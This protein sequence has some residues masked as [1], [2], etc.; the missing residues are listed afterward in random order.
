MEA[1]SLRRGR[2]VAAA[3]LAVLVLLLVLVAQA[4]ADGED[5][6]TFGTEGTAFVG[7]GTDV[8]LNDPDNGG[9][10]LPRSDVAPDGAI[11]TGS[12]LR[13]GSP[14]PPR[15]TSAEFIRVTR[16]DT[17]GTLAG[18]DGDGSVDVDYGELDRFLD[19]EVLP[20][21]NTMLVTQ[22][23]GDIDDRGTG[24][25]VLIRTLGPDGG[26]IGGGELFFPPEE[27]G[28][29]D[30]DAVAAD[31]DAAGRVFVV[32][33]DC[34]G[35]AVLVRYD[36]EDEMA[37]ELPGE[38]TLEVEIGPDGLLYILARDR[39]GCSKCLFERLQR[40]RGFNDFGIV[41]RFGMDDLE[42]DED[43]GDEGAA[44][45]PGRPIDF[46]VDPDSRVVVWTDAP[47]EPTGEQRGDEPET[48]D[49]FRLDAAGDVDEDWA[50][51]GWASIPHPD[52]GPVT[53]GACAGRGG[54]F[55]C[56][57]G[58]PQVMAQSD[59]KVVAYGYPPTDDL[60]NR[61]EGEIPRVFR[62]R[63]IARLTTAGALDPTW[64]G[65][66][67]RRFEMEQP[68]EGTAGWVGLGAGLFQPDGKLL[69]PSF[70]VNGPISSNTRVPTPPDEFNT[71]VSRIGLTAPAAA[72][73][74]PAAA[75]V[76]VSAAS[77][78]C[79]SRRNFPI[80]LRTGRRRAE[81]S[82][83]R[84]ASV[85]VNGK[86]VP[87]TSGARRGAQVDLRNLPRGRFT[88]EIRLTLADGG[89]VRDTRRYRTCTQKIARDLPGLRTRAPKGKR[90]R[91]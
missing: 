64:D 32:W 61:G 36:G 54:L 63:T 50:G 43:Y 26:E 67:V 66:G 21:G 72:A 48:W 16:M 9:A 59:G 60:F 65:D 2:P 46:T 83:I 3:A 17:A 8:P 25:V 31:T 40:P 27:C 14:V 39:L 7:L 42:W 12:A 85:T 28:V 18:F 24:T 51:D 33:E 57:L 70:A 82:P 1:H 89:K 69:I 13:P 53:I 86:A 20:N 80:R 87:V 76:P 68:E 38:G 10:I 88:V 90:K 37:R 56:E 5:D 23:P 35:D 81:R 11:I 74:A 84:Q 41:A 78:T 62:D 45:L 58:V 44:F 22:G 71:G 55:V 52:F 4:R 19:L 15:G 79:V 30:A 29:D 34:E 49:F 77:R 47:E 75:A 73:P 91:R 6:P